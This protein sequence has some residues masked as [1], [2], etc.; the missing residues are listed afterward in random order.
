MLKY[1]APLVHNVLGFTGLEL[2]MIH[3]FQEL[4]GPHIGVMEDEAWSKFSK[5]TLQSEGPLS[6][7]ANS[8]FVGYCPTAASRRICSLPH[9]ELDVESADSGRGPSEDDPG[10]LMLGTNTVGHSGLH[11]FYPTFHLA[12]SAHHVHVNGFGNEVGNISMNSGTV[13]VSPL[14]GCNGVG[15]LQLDLKDDT[16]TS[17]A[18][19]VGQTIDEWNSSERRRLKC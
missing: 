3:L 15:P 13:E 4:P 16:D 6:S 18:V 17:T 1:R 10:Q 2:A 8:N 19:A 14:N 12:S 7:G 11:H 5:A 9:C